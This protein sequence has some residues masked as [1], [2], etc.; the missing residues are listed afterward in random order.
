[1]S[2]ACRAYAVSVTPDHIQMPLYQWTSGHF[3]RLGH[4]T[5]SY[6][7]FDEVMWKMLYQY[8]IFLSHDLIKQREDMMASLEA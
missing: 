1:M 8:P 5:D 3:V 2:K 6:L 4:Y 7:V